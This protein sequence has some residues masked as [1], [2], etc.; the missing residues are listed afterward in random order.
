MLFSEETYRDPRARPQA[1]G[2]FAAAIL[3]LS[4]AGCDR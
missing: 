3:L 4:A 2:L 1:G